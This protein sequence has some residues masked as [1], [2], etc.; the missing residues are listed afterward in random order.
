[1]TSQDNRRLDQTLA[2]GLVALVLLPWYRIRNG[3]FGFDW[4]AD[5]PD[6]RDLW[7]ALAQALTGRWQLWPIFA[8]VALAVMLR[9]TRA[10]GA[11]RGRALAMIGAAGL[12]WMAVEGLSIGL[13]GWNWGLLETTFG[14]V[15]GQPAFGAGA[16]ILGA[17][18]TLMIAFGQAERGALKGDAFVL[19]AGLNFY[20]MKDGVTGGVGYR[21]EFGRNNQTNYSLMANINLR[22]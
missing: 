11:S 10:P 2:A 9:L 4:L 16:L 7:P 20:S 13:R 8:L 19:G 12:V 5:L 18:F 6:K 17:I 1:M 15:T 14:E 3:F 22:F 21:Q